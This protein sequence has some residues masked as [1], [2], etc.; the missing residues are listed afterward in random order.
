MRDIVLT[1][2][3]HAL[4]MV[5]QIKELKDWRYIVIKILN[6]GHLDGPIANPTWKNHSFRRVQ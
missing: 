6:N 5:S 2:H 3:K 4:K 1:M